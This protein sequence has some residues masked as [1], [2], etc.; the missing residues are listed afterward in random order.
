MNAIIK[1]PMMITKVTGQLY[2]LPTRGLV[3]SQTSQTSQLT[4]VANNS[5]CKY[6][7][8]TNAL[9]ALIIEMAYL[10]VF[11]HSFARSV[12]KYP[13]KQTTTGRGRIDELTSL[14]YE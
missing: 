2:W 12:S 4:D 7:E 13:Q 10:F 6:V 9:K 3:K 8:I 1:T 5:S 14:R 11:L